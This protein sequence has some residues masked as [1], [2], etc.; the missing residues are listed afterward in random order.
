[1]KCKMMK[2]LTLSE[3][4][5]ELVKQWDYD[6]NNPEG[7]FPSDITRGSHKVVW[8]KCRKGHSWRA[9]IYHRTAGKGCP[10]CSGKKVLIGYNDLASKAPCLSGEWDYEKNNGI[11]PETVTYGSNR[12]VWWKCRNG[13]SWHADISH[14]YGGN[15]CPYCSGRKV[16]E[17]YNDFASG[18]PS[19][20]EEWDSVKNEGMLPSMVARKSNRK[21]WWKCRKGH[22]WQALVSDRASGKGC[23]YCSGRYAIPGYND[24]GTL[25]KALAEEWDYDKNGV[26]LPRNFT[27]GSEKKV[28]WRCKAGHS[29][30]A[31]IYSRSGGRRNCPYC[32]GKRVL[33]GYNDLVTT[34]PALAMEW[35]YE[36]NDGKLPEHFTQCSKKKV[37]WKCDKD[38]SWLSTIHN[39]TLGNGCPYC[40]GR[41]AIAGYND[42]LTVRPDLAG[43]WDYSRN[44]KICPEQLTVNAHNKVWWKCEKGHKWRTAVYSR[45]NGAGCPYCAGKVAIKT[46][47]IT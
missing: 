37:W 6:K 24:L 44:Q 13:H 43:E 11:S 4:F 45:T 20:A 23:P 1:M 47:F 34:N 32:S 10:Y 9:H 36:R 27:Q 29:W 41:N 35:D 3:E 40:S 22:S 2:K 17:G 18:Y 21:V 46:R 8:W 39:R 30:K 28:W 31:A 38:H 14:R 26:A 5:P 12:K 25:N 33:A 7:V 42:L 16:W 15:G 19:C